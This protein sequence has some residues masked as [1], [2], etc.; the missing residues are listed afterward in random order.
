MASRN[1]L[2]DPQEKA[3]HQPRSTRGAQRDAKKAAAEEV[4][5]DGSA[6]KAAKGKTSARAKP[7]DAASSQ[8]NKVR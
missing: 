2:S 4:T 3:L 5:P 7:E 6:S 1:T 8:P